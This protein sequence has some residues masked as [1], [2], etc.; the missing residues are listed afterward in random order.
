V[1]PSREP[2][3]WWNG[4]S[5]YAGAKQPG[6]GTA[7]ASKWRAL[8]ERTPSSEPAQVAGDARDATRYRKLRSDLDDGVFPRFRI[9]FDDGTQHL[10]CGRM[11]DSV[12]SIH[13]GLKLDEKV[14]AAIAAGKAK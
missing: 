12:W 11:V 2:V 10:V 5:F 13:S 6:E 4:S 3:A 1:V 8:Y 14:D 9:S 7:N